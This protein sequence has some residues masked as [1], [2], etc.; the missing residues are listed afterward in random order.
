[1]KLSDLV[2]HTSIWTGVHRALVE[3]HSRYLREGGLLTTGGRGLAAP[4]MTTDD[5][6]A[7][8][9]AVLGCGTARTCAKDLPKLLALKAD[10]RLSKKDELDR[11]DFFHRDNLKD[12]LLRMFDNIHD[13]TVENWVTNF[14]NKLDKFRLSVA[15]PLELT[16]TFEVD[17]NYVRIK[18]SALF[19][20]PDAVQKGRRPFNSAM[21]T[22]VEFGQAP[23]SPVAGYSSHTRELSYERLKGWGTCMQDDNP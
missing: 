4:D 19:E 13:G 12:A 3:S 2:T 10:R 5:K 6:I 21:V 8:L 17:A 14:G 11:P 1:M 16:V 20:D 23:T 9:V 22:D 18:L 7:L 15:K